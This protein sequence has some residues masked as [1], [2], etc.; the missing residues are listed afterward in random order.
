MFAE[1]SDDYQER[2]EL[3]SYRF[4]VGW[5][6][7]IVFVFSIYSFIFVASDAYP[8]GQLNP[9]HY[10][11]F[12]LVLAL[13]VFA[14]AF[15]TTHLTRDQIPYLRQPAESFRRFSWRV[16]FEELGLAIA[17]RNFRVL[18]FAVLASAVVTG[19]NQ[20]LQIYMNTYFWAFSGEQ[21]RWTAIAVIGG[22]M[23]FLTVL[24]LQNLLDKKYLVV[25]CAV[26][27]MVVTMVPVT[28][29]LLGWAPP[30]GSDALI[31]LIVGTAVINAYFG[32]ITLIMFISM[33]ADTLDMQEYETGLRQ[34]GV[35]NSVMSFSGKATTGAGILIAG[36]LIDHVIGLPRG[37]TSE[38]VTPEMILRVGII[39]AYV[40]PL[41][42]VVWLTLVLKYSITR[43]GHAE[44]QQK[45]LHKRVERDGQ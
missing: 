24:P 16:L 17:N 8:Q 29:R 33:V 13:T 38:Q 31:V 30:N 12:A 23:A 21:L 28:M 42:N 10:Q 44:I 25:T 19:T 40:V 35:F 43:E 22:L 45:L 20:A 3:I 26:A 39:D 1:L 36:L 18:I 32:T 6:V 11:T 4:A 15:L 37:A 9:A 41:F 27:T 34:E 14:G 2:S 5:V 7:G